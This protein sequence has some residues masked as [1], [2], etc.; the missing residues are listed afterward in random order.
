MFNE[1]TA[2]VLPTI[3]MRVYYQNIG[4][5]TTPDECHEHCMQF[6]QQYT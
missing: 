5:A 6:S 1:G 4:I 2:L 3:F